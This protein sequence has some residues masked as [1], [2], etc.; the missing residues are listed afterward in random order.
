MKR[1]ERA[2]ACRKML[3]EGF[4]EV[5]WCLTWPEKASLVI[6]RRTG[7]PSQL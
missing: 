2:E 7:F 1:E 6:Y 4:I 5:R 3:S